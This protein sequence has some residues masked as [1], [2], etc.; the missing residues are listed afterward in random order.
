MCEHT[1]NALNT[2]VLTEEQC[3]QR[4]PETSGLDTDTAGPGYI[5]LLNWSD[6]FLWIDLTLVERVEI[7]AELYLQ[8]RFSGLTIYVCIICSSHAAQ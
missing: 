5:K 1:S 4:S 8:C 2:L 6:P 7:V 3:F